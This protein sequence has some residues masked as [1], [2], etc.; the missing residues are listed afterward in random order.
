L[1][2]AANSQKPAADYDQIVIAIVGGGITGLAAA[3]ELTE[4]GVPF[5]LFEASARLGGIIRTEQVDGFTIEAGPDSILAQKPAALE[6]CEAL[7]LG[8]RLI[9]TTPPRTAFVLREGKLSPLP[10]PSVLGIPT[11]WRGL[12]HYDLLPRTARARLA[13]ERIIPRRKTVEDESVGAFFRRRFGD[14][15]VGAIAEPLLGGIHAGDINTLSMQSLFPRFVEAEARFGSVLRAF[16]HTPPRENGQFRSLVA[17][18]EELVT[19]LEAR[20]PRESIR[21]NS[22]IDSISP[23]DDG[24]SLTSA[25]ETVHAT[26]LVLACPAHVAADLLRPLDSRVADLCREVPY[27]STVS[28][29]MA[30]PRA[31]VGHPLN[32]SGFVVARKSNNLRITAC[33][34]VS[35]KW[36]RRAPA[37]MVLL[38]AY[39]GGS[40]D[41][42]AV[43]KPD[44]ELVEIARRELAP[45]LRLTGPPQL[46]RVYRWRCAGAQHNVGQITR[47]AEIERRLSTRGIFVAGSGFRSVGIPD[48]V[49]DGRAA[50]AA[51]CGTIQ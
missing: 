23:A 51:A 10:S 33:T 46:A 16:R 2:P 24:W 1:L 12:L 18:M 20:L 22:A 15:T 45:I 7:G 14:E 29:A 40:H 47:V 5:R 38:R 42:G 44:D 34:W 41:P 11:T 9:S 50:A 19:G 31:A 21:R 39:V 30:W 37:G 4:R 6:L 49:A 17:G 25:G 26:A 27:V 43:D 32:G 28:I 36:D 35:S 48:C 13:A 8:P 3:F